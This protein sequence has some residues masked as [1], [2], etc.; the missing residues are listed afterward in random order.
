MHA[1]N[2]FGFGA[3]VVFALHPTRL[4]AEHF[5]DVFVEGFEDFQYLDTTREQPSRHQILLE[6]GITVADYRP[7]PKDVREGLSVRLHLLSPGE[8][9]FGIGFPGEYRF[10][11]AALPADEEYLDYEGKWFRMFLE[12]AFKA[13]DI[14]QPSFGWGDDF[15]YLL[16][17]RR[18]DPRRQAFALNLYGAEAVAEI[19]RD[20]L[21]SAPSWKV[22]E[23]PWGGTIVQLAEKPFHPIRTIPDDKREALRKHLRL[24]EINWE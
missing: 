1:K 10:L 17:F 3:T 18:K 20:R 21:R 9:D 5:R 13:F 22:M 7:N 2:K 4:T 23:R 12:R 8:R 15:D 14:L 19:G 24:E 11:M 6:H 16:K